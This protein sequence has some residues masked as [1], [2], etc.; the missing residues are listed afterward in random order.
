VI[1]IVP[2]SVSCCPRDYNHAYAVRNLSVTL[3]YGSTYR[4][5]CL[6]A[7]QSIRVLPRTSSPELQTISF[8]R[9]A[10]SHRIHVHVEPTENGLDPVLAMDRCT[11]SCNLE[12]LRTAPP[13]IDWRSTAPDLNA[14]AAMV[15]YDMNQMHKDNSWSQL[16]N[17]SSLFST[18]QRIT[19]LQAVPRDA[20]PQR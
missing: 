2:D 1:P 3:K 12:A 17:L 14:T 4:R 11:P 19:K 9:K 5:R 13:T 6:Q 8:I 20:F 16:L 15:S 18:S 7:N 10:H